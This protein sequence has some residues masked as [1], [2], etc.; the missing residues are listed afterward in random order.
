MRDSRLCHEDDIREQEKEAR[1]L[2]GDFRTALRSFLGIDDKQD[3]AL[4][5]EVPEKGKDWNEQLLKERE[6]QLSS[7]DDTEE[8]RN[9]SAGI[10]LDADGDVELNESEEKKQTHKTRR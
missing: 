1:K 10:D 6:E 5:R 8:S 7:T 2:Y 4:V 9:I 3:T